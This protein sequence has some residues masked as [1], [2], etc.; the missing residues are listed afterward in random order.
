M[1]SIYSYRAKLIKRMFISKPTVLQSV[2][3]FSIERLLDVHKRIKYREFYR[4]HKLKL[5]R[6]NKHETY[7]HDQAKHWQRDSAD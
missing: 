2:A 7:T 1:R 6:G 3:L 5:F 4:Y